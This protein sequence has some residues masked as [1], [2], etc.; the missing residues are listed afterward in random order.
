MSTAQPERFSSDDAKR[1]GAVPI[2]AQWL[3]KSSPTCAAPGHTVQ[4]RERPPDESVWLRLF[5]TT[6]AERR[7]GN[8]PDYIVSGG[9]RLN[10]ANEPAKLSVTQLERKRRQPPRK[11]HQDD[12]LLERQPE[13]ERQ[14]HLR[15]S[16]RTLTAHQRTSRCLYIHPRFAQ[17]V[18][19]PAS[20][21][22]R[23]QGVWH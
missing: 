14:R 3:S 8:A 19:P 2:P 5:T 16:S 21:L 4:H 22:N 7:Q 23:P 1:L 10:G 13:S 17:L 11:S 9:S 6:L 12:A 20:P 18:P 15:R